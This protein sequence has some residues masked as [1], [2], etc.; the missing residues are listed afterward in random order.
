MNNTAEQCDWKNH[1][2]NSQKILL[3]CVIHEGISQSR[4]SAY[5]A[6]WSFLISMALSTASAAIG[7]SGASL[8]MLGYASEGTVSAAVGIASGIYSHQVSKDAADRQQ[9]ANER[10]DCLLQALHTPKASAV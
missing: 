10:L 5:Q 7:L 1:S 9:R 2:V 3:D 4:Q 8:L 6:H